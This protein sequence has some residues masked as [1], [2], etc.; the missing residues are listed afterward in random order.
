MCDINSNERKGLP[1]EGEGRGAAKEK[2]GP[3][4]DGPALALPSGSAVPTLGHPPLY[5]KERGRVTG[6]N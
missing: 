1:R 4:W 6:V 5:R 2:Q 3:R